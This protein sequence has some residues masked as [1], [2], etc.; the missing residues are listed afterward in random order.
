MY[1]S[2]VQFICAVMSDSLWPH[3]LQLA[4]LPCPSPPPRACSSS[5]PSSRWWQWH[6]TTSLSASNASS[7]IRSADP[8]DLSG[9]AVAAGAP[10]LPVCCSLPVCLLPIDIKLQLGAEYSLTHN[11]YWLYMW[12]EIGCLNHFAS[13]S[14]YYLF[15]YSCSSWG[16]IF[17]PTKAQSQACVTVLHYQMKVG[18][19]ETGLEQGWGKSSLCEGGCSHLHGSNSYITFLSPIKTVLWDIKRPP[20]ADSCGHLVS[21]WGYL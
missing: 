21:V 3:W 18:M 4:R 15:F 9:R 2:S 13:S 17:W 16:K 10:G 20:K 8:W 12:V 7:S 11:E 5:C 6:W 14:Y 1:S 19:K